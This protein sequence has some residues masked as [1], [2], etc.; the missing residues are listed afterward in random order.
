MG[1]KTLVGWEWE[2]HNDREN[3]IQTIK[4]FIT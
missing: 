1:Y 4:D 3:T 2:W